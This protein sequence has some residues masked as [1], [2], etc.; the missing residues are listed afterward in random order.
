M[1]TWRD[2][3]QFASHR[4]IV[5]CTLLLK[6]GR[7]VVGGAANSLRALSGAREQARPRYRICQLFTMQIV[8]NLCHGSR[9]TLHPNSKKKRVGVRAP[10]LVN[11]LSETRQT[12]WRPW[13]YALSAQR[14]AS[15]GARGRKSRCKHGA[16]ISNS[17]R[18]VS[19][20]GAHFCSNLAGGWQAVWRARCNHS[21]ARAPADRRDIAS[22]HLT[23]T[24]HDANRDQPLPRLAHHF[25]SKFE[26]LKSR[27][28][29]AK[30]AEQ[31]ELDEASVLAAFFFLERPRS[32]Q[33]G[34]PQEVENH[35]A[36]MARLSPIRIAS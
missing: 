12:R 36:N 13:F 27:R 6:L 26:K 21:E 23:F 29:G 20:C 28:T 5:W 15:G 32:R 14:G 4:F 34:A 3:L 19:S 33:I 35:D 2:Y 31:V 25:A 24:F 1:Q 9:T 11:R 16:I 22:A 10:N 30:L 7:R 18:I 17:H 8:T